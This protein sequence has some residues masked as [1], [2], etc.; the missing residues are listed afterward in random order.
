MMGTAF[1]DI[2]ISGLIVAFFAASISIGRQYIRNQVDN[3][4]D[5]SNINAGFLKA[6]QDI[7]IQMEVAIAL[8]NEK[9]LSQK[10]FCAIHYKETADIKHTLKLDY[11]KLNVKIENNER[12]IIIL[13]EHIK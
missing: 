4:K 9:N 6:L 7:T 10:E 5:Q 3:N 11:A 1:W 12:R 8:I 13:E 2:L